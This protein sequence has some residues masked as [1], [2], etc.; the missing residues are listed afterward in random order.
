MS[1]ST[2][3][4]TRRVLR[5]TSRRFRGAHIYTPP[6]TLR[7]YDSMLV[8]L[9]AG[10]GAIPLRWPSFGSEVVEVHTLCMWV[11]IILFYSTDAACAQ[12]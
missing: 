10:L 2:L 7:G 5:R 1:P 12:V 3:N 6:L 8:H 9:L 4:Y 11:V